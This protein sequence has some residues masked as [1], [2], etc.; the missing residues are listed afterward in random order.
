MITNLSNRFNK[1][2]DDFIEWSPSMTEYNVFYQ[3]F[4]LKMQK[5]DEVT[6][7]QKSRQGEHPLR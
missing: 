4:N 6:L 7:P 1:R 2:P 3:K 5:W